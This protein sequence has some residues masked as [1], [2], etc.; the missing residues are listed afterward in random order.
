M[1]K[2]VQ[3]IKSVLTLGH[4]PGTDHNAEE[5]ART[6]NR[7]ISAA[8]ASRSLVFINHFPFPGLGYIVKKDK[9]LDWEPFNNL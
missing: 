5:A 9:V 3:G 2:F 8:V 4:T 7:I 6:S 1:S